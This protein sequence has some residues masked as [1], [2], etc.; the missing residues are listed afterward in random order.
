MVTGPLEW[1]LTVEGGYDAAFSKK[2]NLG[3]EEFVHDQV[4][5]MY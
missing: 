1:G 3:K 2:E 5:L 4:T